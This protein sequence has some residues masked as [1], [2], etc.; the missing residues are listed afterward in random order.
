MSATGMALEASGTAEIVSRRARAYV[1]LAKPGISLFM[2]M[3]AAGSCWVAGGGA[4]VALSLGLTTAL[5]AG[6]AAALNQLLERDADARM[7]RTRGRPLPGGV[8]GAGE[9]AGVGGVLTAAGLLWSAAQFPVATT[10]LL[11]MSHVTYVLVYTPLKRITPL[12][13]LAGAVPGALPVLAG[14]VAA[15]AEPGA[16]AWGLAGVLYLWQLPHFLAIGWLCRE[17]YVR[18][19]FRVL[20]TMDADGKRTG[21]QSTI[22][23][24]ALIPVSLVPWSAGSAGPLYLSVALVLGAAYLRLA[25]VL[26]RAPSARHARRLFFGSLIYLPLMFA[27]LLLDGVVG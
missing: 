6:G 24:A 3:A 13:T 2:G 25:L 7:H 12:S 26:L 22:Y 23:A 14:W 4:A 15:G 1:E 8:I 18:G 21:L 16:A 17:D 9:A 20:A 19:G 11:A 10:L 5:A 27:A